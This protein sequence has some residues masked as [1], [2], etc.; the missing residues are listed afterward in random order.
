LQRT[1]GWSTLS[2]GSG[3]ETKGRHPAAKKVVLTL[4]EKEQQRRSVAYVNVAIE[5]PRI[6]REM[7]DRAADELG[8]PNN[9]IARPDGLA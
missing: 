2:R 7:V 4:E 1:Q 3:I 9:V 6:T 8:F 5:N